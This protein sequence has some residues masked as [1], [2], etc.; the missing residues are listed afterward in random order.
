M[1]YINQ[2]D[3]KVSLII[4]F[5]YHQEINFYTRQTSDFQHN[6]P[7][8]VRNLYFKVKGCNVQAYLKWNKQMLINNSLKIK[9]NCCTTEDCPSFLIFHIFMVCIIH[10]I[11]LYIV[12]L[13]NSVV[14]LKMQ[15]LNKT[16]SKIQYISS[17]M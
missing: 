11:Y 9:I 17:H 2:F 7:S 15:S 6:K 1:A 12:I 16:R 10:N 8:I 14:S 3:I 5:D 4:R 13:K